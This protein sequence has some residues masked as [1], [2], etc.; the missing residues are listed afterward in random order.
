MSKDLLLLNGSLGVDLEVLLD[1]GTLSKVRVAC[2]VKG[3]ESFVSSEGG[4]TKPY[5][6]EVIP[7]DVYLQ[8]RWY[9]WSTTR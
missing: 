2:N 4:E 5:C 8:R 7:A 9:S 1:R 3:I 6:W